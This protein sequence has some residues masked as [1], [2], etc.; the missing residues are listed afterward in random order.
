MET[1]TVTLNLPIAETKGEMVRV[2][3][4]GDYDLIF[5]GQRQRLQGRVNLQKH[6]KLLG[7]VSNGGTLF[8]GDLYCVDTRQG[9]FAWPSPVEIEDFEIP[10]VQ[11]LV[12]PVLLM[13]RISND[14]GVRR[15]LPTSN[16]EVVAIDLR[17]GR[18]LTTYRQSLRNS[19]YGGRINSFWQDDH[20]NLF[21]AGRQIRFR[22][23]DRERPPA[24][25]ASLTNEIL[26]AGGL[27]ASPNSE[28]STLQDRQQLIIEQLRQLE[29]Q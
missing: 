11:S 16:L 21:I 7:A 5:V 20:L 8:F 10:F 17:D 28:S 24:A 19:H 2:R 25:P 23:F 22:M 27:A 26:M 3:R 6:S 18:W 15:N 4:R 13:G 1:G 9:R 14:T 12:T 29:K